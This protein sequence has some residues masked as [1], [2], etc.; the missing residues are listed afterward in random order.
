MA[1]GSLRQSFTLP[2][3]RWFVV[4]L[5]VFFLA[6][7]VHYGFKANANRSAFERWRAQILKMLEND[8]NIWATYNYPNPPIM[9]LLLSP[10][11][12]LP[13]I[14]GALSWFYLKVGMTLLAFFWIFRMVGTA[15]QPFPPW[16]KALT[17]L[18]S[19][20][21]IMG[22]L[23][24]GNVNLFILFLVVASL[25]LFCRRQELLAG[26][27]LG[28]AIACK[29]TPALFLGYFLWK[30]SWKTLAGC[31]LGLVV[32]LLVVP[33]LVNGWESNLRDLSSWID[34]M[35]KPYLLGGV[36]TTEHTNQSLPGLLYRLLTHSPSFLA[37]DAQQQPV[38]TGFNNLLALD[39]DLVRRL[40][41]VCMALFALLVV[42]TC[43]VPTAK[44]RGG[45]RLAAE[46][47][48]V[49][50]GMLLFSERTWKHHCVTFVLPFAVLSYYLAVCRPSGWLRNA[51]IAGLA[52]VMLLMA[53]T[54]TSLLGTALGKT[55]QVYGAYVWAY[56]ILL[57]GLVTVLLVP[58]GHSAPRDVTP[59]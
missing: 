33:A 38:A 31:A 1:T 20:R 34:G 52:V 41:K 48:I 22:D 3:Q 11:T 50:L 46:F 59:A 49:L 16:A 45:W 37:Y 7:S 27:V 32:F 51:L 6:L 4:G 39:P 9:A 28:L 30:R 58:E 18:L 53:T 5:F 35:I 13:S 8:E 47:S 15:E 21:P 57:T 14:V 42:W 36:V 56:L 40:V 10:L 19:L 26:V 2:T 17:V 24:H 55:A 29:V 12:K 25:F 54:S 23:E 43:H 44:V